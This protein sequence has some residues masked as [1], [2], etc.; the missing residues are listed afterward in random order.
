M[1]QKKN[2][3][4]KAYVLFEL[5]IALLIISIVL[6]SLTQFKNTFF[7]NYD[8]YNNE[9]LINEDV[10]S[11]ENYIY[12]LIVKSEGVINKTN[13]TDT[14]VL[15][16]INTLQ[17]NKNRIYYLKPEKDK[18]YYIS[19]GDTS[20]DLKGVTKSMFDG[21]NLIIDNLS[22][23]SLTLSDKK[24]ILKFEYKQKSYKFIYNYTGE[25]INEK[26]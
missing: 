20:R 8:K 23:F 25:I 24:I 12:N 17:G 16:F 1:L 2:K 9:I 4:L 5:L 13:I 22:D 21:K 3:K 18:L 19:T 14:D 10:E 6:L 26:S 11:L 7:H 15:V